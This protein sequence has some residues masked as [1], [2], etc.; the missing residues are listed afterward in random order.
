MRIRSLELR[1]RVV[2]EGFWKG[3]HRSPHHGFSVEFSEYRQYAQG[4][5]PRFIDWKVMARTDRVFIKKFED[6]TN[7]RCFMLVDQSRSMEYSGNQDYS[8]ADYAATLAATFGYFLMGQG[9]AV[10]L[11]TF[12]GEVDQFVQAR[13][14]P[15]HLLRLIGQLESRLG[16]RPLSRKTGNHKGAGRGG[17][18]ETDLI[19]PL[20]TVADLVRK[21]GLMVLISDLLAPIDELEVHLGYL[22]AAGHDLVVWQVMDRSELAFEFDKASHFR[23]VESGEAVYID[24]ALARDQYLEKLRRHL[25]EVQGI[26]ERNGIEYRLVATDEPLDHV[27]FDFVSMREGASGKGKRVSRAVNRV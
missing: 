2:V 1:A 17:G 20:K 15:G 7:L 24:P 10:G 14:R 4:D 9:D 22:A 27:L 19:G 26:C 12:D 8:K 23:D 5:D 3:L 6:E 21:R 13:N 11:V 16:D 18:A 25:D